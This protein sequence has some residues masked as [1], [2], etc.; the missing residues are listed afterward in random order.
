[1]KN[2][3]ILH[4]QW[5]NNKKYCVQ[6]VSSVGQKKKSVSP[7]GVARSNHYANGSLVVSWFTIY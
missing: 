1:M 6:L 2:G 3:K 5:V 7:T 4:A